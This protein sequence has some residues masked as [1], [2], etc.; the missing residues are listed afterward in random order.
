[1]DVGDGFGERHVGG[2]QVL[3]GGTLLNGSICQI[4]ERRSHLLFGGLIR[5]K[6]CVAGSHAINVAHFGKGSSPMG[7]LVGPSVV[8]RRVTFPL[9][10]G[11][12]H[13][14]AR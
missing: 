3:D 13:V 1:M 5:A 8:N 11:Q 7:L 2:H 10:P 6:R 12:R 9:V 14:A 4:V